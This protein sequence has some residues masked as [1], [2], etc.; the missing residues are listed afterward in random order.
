MDL[1]DAPA[2]FQALWRRLGDAYLLE[3]I[4]GGGQPG[5]TEPAVAQG[6]LRR[7]AACA[8]LRTPSL[9]LG[10]E[11]EIRGEG[12]VGGGLIFD[13]RLCHLSAFGEP[14]QPE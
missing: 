7:A 4:Y 2:T 5:K 3:A 10:E 11:M 1:F 13:G 12:L 14:G 9:G 6:F 8:T